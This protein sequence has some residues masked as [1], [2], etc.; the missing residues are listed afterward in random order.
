MRGETRI[1][2]AVRNEAGDKSIVKSCSSLYT[3]RFVKTPL[4]TDHTHQAP[5]HKRPHIRYDGVTAIR[6]YPAVDI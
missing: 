4:P 3:F 6:C 2:A 1:N 5:T